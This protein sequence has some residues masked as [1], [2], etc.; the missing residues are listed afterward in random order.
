M[1]LSMSNAEERARDREKELQKSIEK[2]KDE[3]VKSQMQEGNEDLRTV[4]G[5]MAWI[6]SIINSEYGTIMRILDRQ[7]AHQKMIDGANG[8][9]DP[10]SLRDVYKTMKGYQ[11]YRWYV[12]TT[13]TALLI[14][15][16]LEM[17]HV[18][19]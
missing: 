1:E 5:L 14:A 9:D 10:I 11:R 3:I 17:V 4:L 6:L 18:I 7:D 8:G 13:I 16:L 12:A 19:K 15:K 2:L